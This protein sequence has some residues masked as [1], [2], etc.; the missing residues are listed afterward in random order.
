[1]KEVKSSP[2]KQ[3]GNNPQEEM[4]KQKAMVDAGLDIIGGATKRK[5]WENL[6]LDIKMIEPESMRQRKMMDKILRDKDKKSNGSGAPIS[7]PKAYS[8]AGFKLVKTYYV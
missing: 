2:L 7:L 5:N 3:L 8:D 1:M 4:A 6:Q